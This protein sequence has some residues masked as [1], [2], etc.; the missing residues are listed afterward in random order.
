M[1]SLKT[2]PLK[3]TL[4]MSDMLKPY[5]KSVIKQSFTLSQVSCECAIMN[6][7]GKALVCL[8]SFS[9]ENFASLT[10]ETK[11]VQASQRF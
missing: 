6:F 10:C 4:D 2:H 1:L 3:E 8:H 7:P 9:V 5:Y 11:G